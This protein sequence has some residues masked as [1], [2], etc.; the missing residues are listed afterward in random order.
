MLPLD[1]SKASPA[2][3]GLHSYGDVF[4]SASRAHAA[5]RSCSGLDAFSHPRCPR[6]V[7]RI[8]R[9][10]VGL[11]TSRRPRSTPRTIAP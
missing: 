7:V 6:L 11:S 2:G 1:G 10:A 4:G 9:C 5:Y 3:G 8:S